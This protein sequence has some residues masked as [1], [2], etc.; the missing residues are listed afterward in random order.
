M[1]ESL[2]KN[3]KNLKMNRKVKLLLPIISLV[4][5]VILCVGV[6]IAIISLNNT[7]REIAVS[8]ELKKNKKF[9]DLSIEDIEV[10]QGKNIVHLMA[11][12]YNHGD[13]FSDKMVNIVFLDEKE[14]EIGRTPTYISSIEKNGSV[15]IDT[16]INKE[17]TKAYTFKVEE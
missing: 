2:M 4:I 15:R 5:I 11:N 10:E 8:N 1:K 16:V 14:K 6:G 13:A 7:N 17:F 3:K 12:I 9:L